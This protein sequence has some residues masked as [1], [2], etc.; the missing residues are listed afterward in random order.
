MKKILLI[1]LQR[2]L[3]ALSTIGLLVA[4]GTDANETE[5]ETTM[6]AIE[7]Q[8]ETT[9]DTEEAADE[10]STAEKQ[11]AANSPTT[12]AYANISIQPEEA[13]DLYL[14]QYPNAAITQIQ[15]DKEDGVYVY[16]VE[17]FEG[18]TEYELKIHS[19]DA[20]ILKEDIDTD[21]DTDDQPLT[22]EQVA[23]VKALVDQALT[24]AGEGSTLEEWELAIDDGIAKLEVDV[25]KQDG[26]DE[27]RTYN[28][29]TGELLEIDN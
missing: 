29:D 19:V 10:T 18:S 2:G 14:N 28:V 17:G 1:N 11:E 23:K 24:D 5:P 7:E 21:D 25:D 27:E 20:T 26:E 12:D 15:L 3:I 4:C 13:F 8:E 22:R 16:E 6:P 9:T